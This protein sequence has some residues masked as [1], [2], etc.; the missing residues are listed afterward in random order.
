MKRMH[1]L[2][3]VLAIGTL[4]VPLAMAQGR[5]GRGGGECCEM[6]DGK[7][8][9]CCGSPTTDSQACCA[10][11]AATQREDR[12][13]HRELMRD[14]HTLVFN[15]DLVQRTVEEIPG[16]VRTVTTTS[17]PELLKVLQ[18]HPKEMGDYYKDGGMV[19]GWDPVFRALAYYADQVEM[20]VEIIENGVEVTATS[21]D[22]YVVKLIRAHAY[23][24]S[25]FVE[26]GRT[27][28]HEPTPLPE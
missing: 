9:A 5:G 2:Y 14:A 27:A 15:N 17:D 20:K 13:S 18:R 25:D 10:G 6:Q 11:E 23:K 24:V 26:R 12:K 28:M 1:K 3:M 7:S 8:P 16:G 19:R 4:I 21:E 22:E